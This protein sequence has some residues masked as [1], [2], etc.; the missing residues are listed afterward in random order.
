MRNR[1]KILSEKY[2]II[3]ESEKED[4]LGGLDA[5]IQQGGGEIDRML[6]ELQEYGYTNK[7]DFN[8]FRTWI[9]KHFREFAQNNY[10]WLTIKEDELLD[11]IFETIWQADAEN[12]EYEYSQS[13]DENVVDNAYE[14]SQEAAKKALLKRMYRAFKLQKKIEL[15]ESEKEDILGGLD[16]AAQ[17]IQLRK[18]L[19]DYAR[20]MHDEGV[21]YINLSPR[22]QELYLFETGIERET[23]RLA[24]KWA[25]SLGWNPKNKDE[26]ESFEY[27][28]LCWLSSVRYYYKFDEWSNRT[29]PTD[30][31]IEFALDGLEQEVLLPALNH[32]Y[33]FEC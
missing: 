5:F 6:K 27:A 1:Y 32:E 7:P 18:E 28:V 13:D 19:K 31:Q 26:K 2:S 11:D 33:T 29:T 30:L 15:K 25:K 22:L 23:V 20:G 4:I 14:L 17:H 24:A 3:K 16:A 9:I 10:V 8:A 12:Y 21:D